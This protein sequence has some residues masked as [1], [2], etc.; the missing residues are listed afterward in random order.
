[1]RKGAI[2]EMERRQATRLEKTLPV[3]FNLPEAP[4]APR[5]FEALSRN[6]S[7]GG[8]FI[9]SDLAQDEGLALAKD[10]FLNL[11]IE[12][13]DRAQSI[14]PK[15]R[16]VWISKKSRAP[17]KIR[18]GFG[19]KFVQINTQE[20]RAI[21]L[22]ISREMFTQSQVIEKEI[23]VISR[24]Q[25]L[26]DRQRRNLEILDSIRKNRLISR[27]EISKSTGIN[28]VTISN[29]IDTYLKKGLVFERGLDISSGG[30]RPEL[31]EINP[32]YGYVVGVDLG[33]L[34]VSAASMQVVA[35][36]F[37]AQV[38]A[39]NKGKRQ[40]ESI[41]DSLDVLKDLIAEVC[42]SDE[43][44]REK[45]RGIGM[46]ISGIMDKF[47]GTVRNPLTATTFANYVTIKKELEQEFGFPVFVE[48]S[49]SCALFAEK[50][51][52]ISSEAKAA[53]NIIY[54][55]SDNQCAI[56]LKGELYNGSSKSAGQLNFSFPRNNSVDSDYC[57]MRSSSDCIL[58]SQAQ[59]S[60]MLFETK[61]QILAE[62]TRLGARIAYLVNVFNPQV[63]IVGGRF[64]QLGDMFL[65][66]VRRTVSRWAFRE[67]AS[68][69]RIIPATL[70]EDAVAA[71]SAS[72]VIE[73]AFANI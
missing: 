57:W 71:G 11:E 15:G 24:E 60:E 28:I 69:V 65:D 53:D 33:P 16:I 64:S 31:V 58:R 73:S 41:E 29:Y 61:E 56:M 39:K 37:M 72:L 20:K 36:D 17:R 35:T 12:L 50:W 32:H 2:S 48:N 34:N 67:A 55:F 14:K 63:V 19:V 62:G 13:L 21:S 22:F 25:K 23:P 44:K 18:S 45:I 8:V 6:I 9:E 1:M 51:T 42:A 54:I 4:V 38:K 7:E 70:G 5:P 66:A 52:G 47:G 10:V 46:G 49:A 59:D 30:R 68:I 26:T 43:V 3:R 40:D 27:A